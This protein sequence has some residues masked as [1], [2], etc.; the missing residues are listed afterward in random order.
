MNNPDDDR[1]YWHE[2]CEEHMEQVANDACSELIDRMGLERAQ[3]ILDDLEEFGDWSGSEYEVSRILT[4]MEMAALAGNYKE[5]EH[6]YRNKRP[7]VEE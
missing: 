5:F 4:W 2:H 3:A 7:D 6:L 1:E